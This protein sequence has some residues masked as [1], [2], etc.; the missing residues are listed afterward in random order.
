MG[1]TVSCYDLLFQGGTLVTAEAVASSDLAIVDGRIVATG[2]GLEGE[3]KEI[4]DAS[5]MHLF[6]GFIDAHVHF[7]EP[8]RQHWEGL[9]S[10]PRS[11]A[12]GGGTCFF[13]MPLNA[14]PPTLDRGE[15]ERKRACAEAKSIL[16]F[17]LWGGLTPINLDSLEGLA[18]AG[19]IGFKAFMSRSGTSD[20]PHSDVKVLRRGMTT[21]ASRGLP[22]AVH[23]EDD[24]L[25][26]GLAE[27]SRSQGRT[28][29]RDYISS[30]PIEAELRAINVVLDLAGELGCD[31]H[32]VHVSSPEGIDLIRAAKVAGIRVTAETCPHFLLL[33]DEDVGRLGAVA[34]CAPA[35]RDKTHLEE[36]WERIKAGAIDTLGSDH[37]PAPPELK[38]SEDFFKV[39]GGIAGCQH[40]F[41]LALAEWLL[42]F[43]IKEFPRFSAM[44]A[45]NVAERFGLGRTKGRIA[46]GF[47]ADITMIDLRE[48]LTITAKELLYRHRISPYVGTVLRAV[49]KGTWVRGHA[50]YRNGYFPDSIRGKLLTPNQTTNAKPADVNRSVVP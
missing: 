21:A 32:I 16:D 10:G 22:V 37:S 49:I 26:H 28:G 4:V 23:A 9:V 40:A 42:R 7:N 45:A 8:G 39:W 20:F 36:M 38:V 6:P 44:T 47:D 41:P 3:A 43:G 27:Q 31:V 35:L 29:W 24:A 12:A 30:R 13:E 34:K 33:T 25:T 18:D 50:V 2:P 14:H 11:L 15:F 17:A 48:S 5:G 19:V 46:A 1:G